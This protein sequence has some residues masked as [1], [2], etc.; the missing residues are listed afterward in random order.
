[1]FKVENSFHDKVVS[2]S[3]ENKSLGKTTSL[4][5][6]WKVLQKTLFIFVPL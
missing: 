3:Q 2:L 1:M 6:K 4:V 5:H